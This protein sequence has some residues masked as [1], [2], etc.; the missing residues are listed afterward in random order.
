MFFRTM[1]DDF[2]EAFFHSYTRL[3][4]DRLL[5]YLYDKGHSVKAIASRLGL[6]SSSV[7]KRVNAH[8]G[9]GGK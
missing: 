4:Q 7:Y 6:T 1:T 9:R 5:Q 2:I 3:D 8:R